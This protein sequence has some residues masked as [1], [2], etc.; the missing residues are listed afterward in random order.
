MM[1]SQ[2]R[3]LIVDD[4]LRS[5]EGLRALLATCPEVAVI[6]EAT[7]GQEAVSLVNENYPDVVL[8]DV[9][10]PRMNGLEATRLI[11]QEHPR[12]R[13]IVLTLYSAYRPCALSAGADAFLVKGVSSKK[14]LETIVTRASA[15][16]PPNSSPSTFCPETLFCH[17]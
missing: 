16:D 2:V 3:V 11:K 13:V 7:N 8:L 12:T 4:S 10:M 1:A 6:G 14:L 15:V 5:R 9:R 17:E